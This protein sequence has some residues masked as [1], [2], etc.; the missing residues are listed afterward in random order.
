M[1]I[2]DFADKIREYVLTLLSL[3][4]QVPPRPPRIPPPAH[5]QSTVLH[6][7]HGR[8]AATVVLGTTSSLRLVT[9]KHGSPRGA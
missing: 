3:S 7:L 2:P 4:H 6:G 5:Q 1:G 9:R 8:S